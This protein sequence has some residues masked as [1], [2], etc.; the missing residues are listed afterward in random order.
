MPSRIGI[1]ISPA[2]CRI[3]QIDRSGG[4]ENAETIVRAVSRASSPDEAA[5]APYYRQPVAAVVWGLHGDHRQA[6]VAA[7]SYER[8]RREAVSATRQAGVDTR[9]ML[10]DIAPIATGKDGSR[11]RPVVVALAPTSEVAAVVRQLTSAGLRVRSVVTPALALMS[12][13]RLRLTAP[14][15][16]EAYVALEETTTAIALIRDGGLI[17]AR[18]LEWGYQDEQGQVR[19]RDEVS[20]RVGAA[21]EEFL[22]DC[23]AR[24]SAV[25]QVCVCGGLPELRSMTLALTARLDVEV[26]PLDSLFGI[27]ADHLPAGD[28]RDHAA[29][30]R[31]AWAVAAD[32]GAPINFLRE[33]RR[34]LVKVTLTR[35]AVIAGVATGLG[36]AWRIQRSAW[37]EP[38]KPAPKPS[39]T[40][41]VPPRARPALASP[42]KAAPVP[43]PAPVAATPP[44]AQVVS[45]PT[46]AALPPVGVPRP[47]RVSQSP[48]PVVLT[49][50]PEPARPAP[51]RAPE[52]SSAS[53][54]TP[55]PRVRRPPPEE[56]PLPFDAALG[57]ILYGADRKL[58]II[59]GRIVQVGD[60]VRGA[61]VMEIT[62]NSVLFRD[63][64]GRLRRLSLQGPGR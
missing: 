60:E 52:T 48:P 29:E 22:G 8:M 58:A 61:R 37:L 40:S 33:R 1:E 25:A 55:P 30:M 12:L 16:A 10:A 27:D 32:W 35:A 54:T 19:S 57:T 39:A 15:T 24:P 17:A 63:P 49:P 31:L 11:R 59:D 51:P 21:I 23:G 47:A 38:S 9:Q 42:T 56:V 6:V 62:P 2:A 26:E 13:A 4:G 44:P 28:F 64:E 50:V 34:R 53:V 5:L 20:E 45:R 36:L 41:T 18:E 43:A 7:G 3:V 14:G 46:T